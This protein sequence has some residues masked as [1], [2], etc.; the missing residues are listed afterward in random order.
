MTRIL[1]V[2]HGRTAWN[3]EEIFRGTE[4]IPLDDQ[5]RKE[6][7]CARDHLKAYTIHAA[8]TSPLSRAVETAEIILSPHGVRAEVHQGLNDLNYGDWQGVSHEEVKRRYPE[9]Y[10]QWKKAPHTVAFP[11]GESLGAVR[12]RA[13]RV[14]QEVVERY[15][16]KVV[17]LAAHRVVNKVLIAALLGL[18]NS[19]FWEI[20]Q[21]T[22][23]INIFDYSEGRWTCR[24]VNDT[25]HLRGLEDRATADF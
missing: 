24:L 21:D 10:R 3:K 12:D 13:L 9:L 18:D 5:G 19:H 15:P 16:G 17:L 23:A 4:D 25:C 1:L 7:V 8:L 22:A 2:R 11:N 14:T 6:A 20:G